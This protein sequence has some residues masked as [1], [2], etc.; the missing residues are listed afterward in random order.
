[1]PGVNFYHDKMQVCQNCGELMTECSDGWLCEGCDMETSD[2]ILLCR[3]SDRSGFNAYEQKC[4]DHLIDAYHAF[5]V[6]PLTHP[7][8]RRD[9]VS[10]LHRLQDLLAVRIVRRM[11]SDYWVNDM[12]F[13]GGR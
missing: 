6:L 10:S 9:F 11:Y 3:F 2:D 5:L 4:M 1:M 13:Q 8:E 7:D 12:K